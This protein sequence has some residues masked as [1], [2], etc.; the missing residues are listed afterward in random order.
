LEEEGQW[1]DHKNR[2]EDVIQTDAAN[3]SG[4]RTGKL[5]QEIRSGGRRLGRPWP[6]N[7]PKRHR[8]R[9]LLNVLKMNDRIPSRVLNT[10]VK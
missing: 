5:Q 3:C 8:R 1:G 4:F 10:E 2:W 7:G 6:E 9:H